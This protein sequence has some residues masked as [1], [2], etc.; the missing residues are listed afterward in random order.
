MSAGRE[1]DECRLAARL[2][3]APVLALIVLY[4][5]LM[6]PNLNNSL[7]YQG[8]ESYYTISALNMIDR[9]EYLA[10][11][12]EGEYRF[13]KPILT[14]WVAVAGYKLFG[15]SMWSARVPI[16]L[17]A[18]LTIFTTYRLAL[19]TLGDRRKALLAAAT[20][21]ASV[22]FFSFS[23][24]A[25]TE[26]VLV[27]FTVPAVFMFAKAMADGAHA[28]RYAALGS[29]FVGLAFMTK[30]P[31]G[32]LPYAAA[33]IHCSFSNRPE[34]RKLLFA[35]VNP[36]NLAI[37]AAITVPWYAYAASSHPAAFASDMGTESQSMGNNP[38]V[39]MVRRLLFY[40]YTL[41]IYLFPFSL[42]GTL[43]MIKRRVLWSKSCA[44]IG[45]Y[46]AIHCLTFI[47]FVGGHRSRYLLP[48]VPLLCIVLADALFPSGWKS[49]MK[50]AGAVL[51]LQAVF[52]AA[53]PFVAHEALR[54]LTDKWKDGYSAAGSLGTTLEMKRAGWCR[55][56][57]NN[58]NIVAPEAADFL[59]IGDADLRQ[60]AGWE[61]IGTAV[62]RSSPGWSQGKVSFKN[63]MFHLVRRPA[64]DPR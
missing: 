54:E 56:Y 12:Y 9:G 52:Y 32:L 49:W 5:I 17:L 6:L 57:A 58:R 51:F 28:R 21:A 14:Y 22:M 20:L 19:F 3:D 27:F 24:T 55:L 62:H 48:I 50:T 44:F 2:P 43:L 37:V 34:K 53:H 60:Y 33:L 59:I 30:G 31:V 16:L 11:F 29:A 38:V 23:R 26:M 25:M 7:P 4:F 1:I 8:D 64:G 18:C 41:T 15:A 47:L 42:A 45:T 13:N 35:L 61:I 63:V 46:I 40:G 39:G 10:P 36:L